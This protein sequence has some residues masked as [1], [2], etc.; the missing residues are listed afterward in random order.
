MFVVVGPGWFGVGKVAS[1]S[2]SI[3]EKVI[4]GLF[5]NLAGSQFG[6]GLDTERVVVFSRLVVVV[7]QYPLSFRSFSLFSYFTS[8]YCVC[9]RYCL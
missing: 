7:R 6:F 4:Y 8:A 1:L 2:L 9:T 5:W 3:H